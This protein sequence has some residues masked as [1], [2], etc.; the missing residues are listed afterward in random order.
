MGPVPVLARPF[1][2]K[3]KKKRELSEDAAYEIALQDHPEW[4]RALEN[5][6]MPDEI[7][8]PDGQ[9][10]SPRMH[11]MLHVIVERQ[12]AAD[13]PKGVVAIAQELAK[14]GVSHHNIR[15]EIG[16]AVCQQLWQTMKNKQPFDERQ[17]FADLREIADSHR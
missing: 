3:K 2:E 14:L 5:D 7:A 16:Q 13:D 4:R 12:L 17:Y 15:H 6:S 11:L 1:D 9:P 10:M 8:G